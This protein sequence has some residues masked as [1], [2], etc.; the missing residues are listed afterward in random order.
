MSG[1]QEEAKTERPHKSIV[2]GDPRKQEHFVKI[3]GKLVNVKRPK[4]TKQR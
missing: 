1:K 3:D 4:V 2:F